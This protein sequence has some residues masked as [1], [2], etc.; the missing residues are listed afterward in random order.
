MG[1]VNVTIALMSA[2]AG[3]VGL[4]LVA[5]AVDW[6]LEGVLVMLPR[7]C[8]ALRPSLVVLIGM[9]SLSSTTPVMSL[10][11]ARAGGLLVGVE[12]G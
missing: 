9:I 4:F 8:L 2:G 5:L 3:M 1:E 10:K 12:G 11:T 7:A 6:S